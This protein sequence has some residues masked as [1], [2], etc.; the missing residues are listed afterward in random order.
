M[1]P[2]LSGLPWIEI[3]LNAR[4][5][6]NNTV[7]HLHDKVE[8]LNSLHPGWRVVAYESMDEVMAPATVVHV[9]REF[10]VV[11]LWVEWTQLVSYVR[12]GN[13]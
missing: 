8:L 11:T 5:I 6:N 4:D 2:Q 7:V 12:R 13:E 1:H 9:D 10:A 3:D